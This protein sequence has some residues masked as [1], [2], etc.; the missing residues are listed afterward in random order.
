[1]RPKE[2]VEHLRKLIQHSSQTHAGIAGGLR[3]E[4]EHHRSMS[5]HH[6]SAMGKAVAGDPQ[7]EFHRCTKA[8]HDAMAADREQRASYHDTRA[9]DCDKLMEEC[10][11]VFA[12]GDLNKAASDVMKRLEH[13]EGQVVPSR[14]SGVAPDRPGVRAVPRFGAQPLAARPEVP[15]QFEKLIVIEE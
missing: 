4:A 8:E 12:S 11:K 6:T 7:H 2:I 13:L 15:V 5:K 3:K 9:A 14:V 10:E 1:M